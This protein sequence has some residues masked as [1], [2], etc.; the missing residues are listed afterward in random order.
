MASLVHTREV[1]DNR[2]MNNEGAAQFSGEGHESVEE[3]LGDTIDAIAADFDLTD[4]Q[5]K[6]VMQVVEHQ[7]EKEGQEL[8]A[9]MLEH[10]DQKFLDM[11]T[12]VLQTRMETWGAPGR[13]FM[14]DS[15]GIVMGDAENPAKA[16]DI[17]KDEREL[18]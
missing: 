3:M 17:A 15:Q 13:K 4:A 1:Y 14:T 6:E 7:V 5:R 11:V 9:D 16:A 2:G 18:G 8:S 12:R 10:P